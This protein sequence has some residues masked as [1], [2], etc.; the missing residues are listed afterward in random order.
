MGL[1]QENVNN[2]EFVHKS[3]SLEFLSHTGS[4]GGDRHGHVVHG[5]DFGGLFSANQH[6]PIAI[7]T[8]RSSRDSIKG[9]KSIVTT[10]MVSRGS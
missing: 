1:E 2:R 10:A 3:L 9:Y 8:I 5:L 4:D 7:P 6:C